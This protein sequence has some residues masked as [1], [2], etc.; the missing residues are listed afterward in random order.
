MNLRLACADFTFPLLEHHHSLRLISMLGFTGVDI[1]LFEGRSHLWPSK[2]FKDVVGNAGSL[3]ATLDDFGLVVADIFLQMEPDF[4]PYAINHPERERR[5]QARDWYQ[6]TLDY[7]ASCGAGHVTVLPGAHF[8]GESAEDSLARS[9]SELAWRVERANEHGVVLGTEAH[10]GSVA[11]DPKT[12]LTLIG[13][14]PGLTLTL[15][16]THFTRIGLPD[17]EVEPL[18]QHASHLHIRGAREGRLQVNFDQ[19]TI[20]YER[21]FRA[22]QETG[23]TGWVGIEYVWTEWERCNESDNL[24]ETVRYRDLFRKLGAEAVQGES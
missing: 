24:S 8:A 11:P 5:A 18:L 1:G 2:E 10:V 22:M 15:D 16:Y 6:R 20:D 23:Y 14:T 9:A 3:R 13:Q 21:V 12:A 17:A 4:V 7:A 19:N